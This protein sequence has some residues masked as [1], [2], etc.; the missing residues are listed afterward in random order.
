MTPAQRTHAEM[1]KDIGLMNALERYAIEC[2]VAAAK[3]RAAV[4]ALEVTADERS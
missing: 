2:E 1:A 3:A 4:K